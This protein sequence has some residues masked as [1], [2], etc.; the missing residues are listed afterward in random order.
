[1]NTARILE[2]ERREGRRRVDL[3]RAR[4][5]K[6]RGAP[7]RGGATRVR[8]APDDVNNIRAFYRTHGIVCVGNGLTA[9]TRR[10]IRS[11]SRRLTPTHDV[12]EK[13]RRTVALRRSHRVSRAVY[14]DTRLRRVFH[15]LHRYALR[16]TTLPVEYRQ[17]PSDSSGMAWHKDLL[18]TQPRQ[19]EMVYTVHNH[20]RNTRLVWKTRGKK[21]MELRPRAGD[22]VF[23]LPNRTEHKVTSMRGGGGTRAILKFIAH[24]RGAR[25]LK[26]FAEEKKEAFL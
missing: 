10:I 21:K 20:N 14:A 4:N 16:P 24:P 18:L 1:M 3:R 6:T 26:R 8:F 12:R 13:T 17:Y 25:K 11:Q 7:L 5:Q 22:V 15:A 2:I 19:V 23:V 9:R